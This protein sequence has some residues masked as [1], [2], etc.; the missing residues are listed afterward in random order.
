MRTNFSELALFVPPKSKWVVALEQINNSQW[1]SKIDLH[2][3]K[4]YLEEFLSEAMRFSVPHPIPYQGS[5]RRLAV[6]ILSH[7]PAQRYN[8]LIEPFAGSAAV[9]LAAAKKGMFSSYVIGDLLE[10]LIQLWQSIIDDPN[11][12]AEL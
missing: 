6:A 5:K 8:R 7:V 10:P 1:Q 4:G 3:T 9:T 12:V 2:S 11:T